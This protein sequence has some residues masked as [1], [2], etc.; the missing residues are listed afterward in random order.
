M[1]LTTR[2]Y[3]S[4]KVGERNTAVSFRD[5]RCVHRIAPAVRTPQKNRPSKSAV[6]VV[7]NSTRKAHPCSV[8]RTIVSRSG[9]L[10]RRPPTAQP[11]RRQAKG[12][13]QKKP[14]KRT[15]APYVT[16]TSKNTTTSVRFQLLRVKAEKG[17][18]NTAFGKTTNSRITQSQ[19]EPTAVVL[20]KKKALV[21]S[22]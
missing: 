14:S 19:G 16:P 4:S 15:F 2:S 3:R 1:F 20:I 18:G 11:T 8:R 17:R 5:M 10:A 9:P 12:E 7:A 22:T 21:A 6:N 13:N